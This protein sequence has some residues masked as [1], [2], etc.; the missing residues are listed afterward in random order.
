MSVI[1]LAAEATTVTLNGYNLTSLTEGDFVTLAPV[2][3]LTSHTNASAGG[4]NIN[5]RVD[6][7]VMDMTVRVQKLSAD[8]VFLNSARNSALPTVF[9]G[10]SKTNYNRDGVD[11]VETYTLESGSIT[12]Q[13]TDTK[14]NQD[15][16]AMMEYVIRFR[17]AVRSL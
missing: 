5:G 11:A 3:P 10:S 15:G 4:V 14:N 8:D 1:I 2:N 13:P 17:S 16:N 7:A 6:G 12:T 9:N